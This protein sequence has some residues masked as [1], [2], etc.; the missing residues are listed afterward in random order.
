[1]KPQSS[2]LRRSRT[3]HDLPEQEVEFS[4]GPG[5]RRSAFGFVLVSEE[6]QEQNRKGSRQRPQN[7]EVRQLSQL[8]ARTAAT[9]KIRGTERRV[10]DKNS[11]HVSRWVFRTNGQVPANSGDKQRQRI[12]E[13]AWTEDL[14]RAQPQQRPAFNNGQFADVRRM[15]S[16]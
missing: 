8:A 5:R 10:T 12:T 4:Q 2:G 6:R 14:D 1:M 3:R 13:G 11:G 9:E 15:I 7:G 16:R